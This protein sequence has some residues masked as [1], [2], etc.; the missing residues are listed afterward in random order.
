[1]SVLLLV[2]VVVLDRFS[3]GTSEFPA[4]WLSPFAL[5]PSWRTSIPIETADDD[6]GDWDM[7]LNRYS[8]ARR[9]LRPQSTIRRNLT[10]V[11]LTSTDLPR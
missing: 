3:G 11:W 8:A 5:L 1:M 10:Q 9:K 4:R 7:T 6:Q 2:L